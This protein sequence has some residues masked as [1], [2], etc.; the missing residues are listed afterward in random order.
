VAPEGDLREGDLVEAE[1]DARD[2]PPREDGP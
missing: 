1:I 2:L